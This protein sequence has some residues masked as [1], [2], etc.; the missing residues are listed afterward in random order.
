MNF[1]ISQINEMENPCY[2]HNVCASEE[3]RNDNKKWNILRRM[4]I[5]GVS[6]YGAEENVALK[7]GI[8]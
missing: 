1:L 7:E 6:E 5:E 8:T 3:F 2:I 4:Y